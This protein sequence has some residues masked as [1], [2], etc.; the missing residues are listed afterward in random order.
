MKKLVFALFLLGLS[1]L[2]S[3]QSLTESKENLEPGLHYEYLKKIYKTKDYSTI[4][5]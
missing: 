2:A 5:R 1:A 3:A 4:L